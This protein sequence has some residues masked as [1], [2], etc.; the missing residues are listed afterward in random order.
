MYTNINWT[1]PASNGDFKM[2]DKQRVV[3]FFLIEMREDLKTEKICRNQM[4]MTVGTYVIHEF[5]LRYT[6]PFT[7][8]YRPPDLY[9]YAV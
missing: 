8:V 4:N 9:F 5:F 1:Y 3:F 7:F 6:M 2:Q